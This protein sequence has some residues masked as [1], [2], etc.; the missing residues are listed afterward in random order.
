VPR[1]GGRRNYDC[2]EAGANEDEAES[3]PAHAPSLRAGLRCVYTL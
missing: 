2:G 1:V 3:F